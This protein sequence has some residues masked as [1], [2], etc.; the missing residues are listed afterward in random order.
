MHISPP[1]GSNAEAFDVLWA[2]IGYGISLFLL[3]RFK[4][5]GG[6]LQSSRWYYWDWKQSSWQ[7]KVSQSRTVTWK[8]VTLGG[9]LPNQIILA[10]D[11]R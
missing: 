8:Q 2:W 3:D 11:T 6:S 5:A 9:Y 7:R 4:Q 10:S 1:S